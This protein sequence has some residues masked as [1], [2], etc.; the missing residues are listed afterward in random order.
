MIVIGISTN[1]A[2]VRAIAPVVRLARLES[3]GRVLEEWLFVVDSSPAPRT[4]TLRSRFECATW[5]RRALS[6]VK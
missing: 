2:P 6:E 1:P 4:P 3:L 5:L